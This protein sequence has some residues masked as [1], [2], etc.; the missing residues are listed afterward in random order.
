M[1]SSSSKVKLKGAA[2]GAA[3]DKAGCVTFGDTKPLSSSSTAKMKGA[4]SGAATDKTGCVTS[5]DAN[6]FLRRARPR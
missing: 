5:G 6:R 3:T 4:A 1:S 2:P